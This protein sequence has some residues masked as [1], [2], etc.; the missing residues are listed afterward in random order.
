MK[1]DLEAEE[2]ESSV[3][4]KAVRE[5]KWCLRQHKETLGRDQ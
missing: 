3:E 2:G 1:R 4:G 5:R